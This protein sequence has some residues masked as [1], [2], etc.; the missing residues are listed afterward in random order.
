[1]LGL[2]FGTHVVLFVHCKLL[3][4]SH[5]ASATVLCYIKPAW[6]REMEIQWKRKQLSVSVS[7][8]SVSVFHNFFVSV[9]RIRIFPFPL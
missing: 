8:F 3:L 4:H 6:W 2:M 1:M 5:T 9:N 7:N